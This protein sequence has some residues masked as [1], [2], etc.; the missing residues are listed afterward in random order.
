MSP[1][2]PRTRSY[3]QRRRRARKQWIAFGIILAITVSALI[4][5]AVMILQTR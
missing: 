3:Q 2:R 1:T 5:I 4:A